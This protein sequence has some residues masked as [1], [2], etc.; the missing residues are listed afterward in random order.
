MSVLLPTFVVFPHPIPCCLVTAMN[1]AQN[2]AETSI[3][4]NTLVFMTILCLHS[5][6]M[7][8]ISFWVHISGHECRYFYDWPSTCTILDLE[9]KKTGETLLWMSEA[10]G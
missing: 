1:S 3:M 4:I 10:E 2:P 7:R 5:D 6:T 8:D 9:I